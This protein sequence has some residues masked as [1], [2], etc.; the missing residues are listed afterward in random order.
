MFVPDVHGF[1]F[2]LPADADVRLH[3]LYAAVACVLNDLCCRQPH[4]EGIDHERLSSDMGRH[5][6]V[7]LIDSLALLVLPVL[8]FSDLLCQPCE[9]SNLLYDNYIA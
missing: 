5:Q 7:L 8:H 1:I 4:V 6:L 3:G 2:F 9:F